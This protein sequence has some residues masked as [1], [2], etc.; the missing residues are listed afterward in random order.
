MQERQRVGHLVGVHEDPAASR[1]GLWNALLPSW[2]CSPVQVGTPLAA[3]TSTSERAL[4]ARPVTTRPSE[5][6]A[7]VHP[8]WDVTEYHGA[9]GRVCGWFLAGGFKSKPAPDCV[10]AESWRVDVGSRFAKPIAQRRPYGD[11]DAAARSGTMD[12]RGRRHVCSIRTLRGE[13]S[14]SDQLQSGGREGRRAPG[15]GLAKAGG[16]A[17]VPT[18]GAAKRGRLDS[19]YGP[20]LQSHDL[21]DCSVRL[22]KSP[23][24]CNGSCYHTRS[25]PRGEAA[26]R[27]E[28]P[29]G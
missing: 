23:P 11:L 2:S 19:K 26:T 9:P 6:G 28:R 12:R 17:L 24:R 20:I 4:G 21:I 5:A 3:V 8:T 29:T 27:V 14:L 25:R 7:R 18:R 22:G 15:R 10:S 13:M 16:R 1:N